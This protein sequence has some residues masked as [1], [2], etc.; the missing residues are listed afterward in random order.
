MS[1]SYEGGLMNEANKEFK[2]KVDKALFLSGDSLSFNHNHI[3]HS[4]VLSTCSK[5]PFIWSYQ[6]E[7]QSNQMNTEGKLHQH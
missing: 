2:F 5:S 7:C 1:Y 6:E 3:F 4:S